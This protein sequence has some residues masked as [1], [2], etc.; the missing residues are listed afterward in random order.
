M[1]N[2]SVTIDNFAQLTAEDHAV[3]IYSHSRRITVLRLRLNTPRPTMSIG[4]AEDVVADQEEVRSLLQLRKIHTA[5]LA[6]L[7]ADG[8]APA[9]AKAS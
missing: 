5:A 4:P 7:D 3:A 9:T 6:E 2:T 1:S 8:S